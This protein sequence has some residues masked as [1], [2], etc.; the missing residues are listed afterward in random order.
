MCELTCA[1]N[2]STVIS[3]LYIAFKLSDISRDLWDPT[4]T[5]NQKTISRS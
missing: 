3:T 2:T 4:Y 5:E 1:S